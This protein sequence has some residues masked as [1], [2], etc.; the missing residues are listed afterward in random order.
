MRCKRDAMLNYL[1]KELSIASHK[2][3]REHFVEMIYN[4]PFEPKASSVYRT[5]Y[6]TGR[7]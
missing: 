4:F 5:Q 3:K 7:D 6:Y 2:L 1:F